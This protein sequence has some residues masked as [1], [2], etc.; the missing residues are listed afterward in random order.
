MNPT[1][2]RP[3]GKNLAVLVSPNLPHSFQTGTGMK[4]LIGFVSVIVT[5]L[6][7]LDLKKLRILSILIC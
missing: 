6:L 5:N 2:R 4:H 7:Y 1:R 3:G